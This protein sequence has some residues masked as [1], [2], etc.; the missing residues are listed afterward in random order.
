MACRLLLR[1]WSRK[2]W[3]T[4]PTQ[5]RGHAVV[6]VDR[7]KADCGLS[8]DQLLEDGFVADGQCRTFE[9][10]NLPLTEISQHAGDGFA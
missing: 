10:G 3:G 9:D 7:E 5:E 4:R 6:R 1:K 2:V 8:A